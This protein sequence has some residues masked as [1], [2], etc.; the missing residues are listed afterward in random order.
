MVWSSLKIHHQWMSFWWD[1][2]RYCFQHKKAYCDEDVSCTCLLVNI[3]EFLYPLVIFPIGC[4]TKLHSSSCPLT[5]CISIIAT[6]FLDLLWKSKLIEEAHETMHLY[7]WSHN[8]IGN[9]GGHMCVLNL[10]RG[11]RKDH[12]D[13][14]E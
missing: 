4:I 10:V 12:Y 2:Y 11:K 8:K 1:I 9:Q 5:T 6:S 3:M 7:K 14:H 13:D